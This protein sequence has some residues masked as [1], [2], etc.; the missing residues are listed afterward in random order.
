MKILKIYDPAM[1][2]PTGVC[3]TAVDTKLLQFANFLSTL[4]KN[5]FEVKRYGLTTNPREYVS[6]NQVSKILNEEGVDSLPLIFLDD[7]LIFKKEYPTIFELG[8]KIGLG[9]FFKKL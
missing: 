5:I 7:E 4:D 9:S 8:S 6:N 1:C 3:G 2:C